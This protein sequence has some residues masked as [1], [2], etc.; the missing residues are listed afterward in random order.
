[1]RVAKTGN[2]PDR[3][4]DNSVTSSLRELRSDWL[5]GNTPR[6]GSQSAPSIPG[7]PRSLGLRGWKEDA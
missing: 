4:A 5:R 1:M 6:A 7:Q 2:G 3:P